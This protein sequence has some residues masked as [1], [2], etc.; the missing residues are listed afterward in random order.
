M[1][2]TFR[3]LRAYVAKQQVDDREIKFKQAR[4]TRS[5]VD[6]YVDL[7][8]AMKSSGAGRGTNYRGPRQTNAALNEYLTRL[9]YAADLDADIDFHYDSEAPLA[10]TFFL[11]MPLACGVTR[12]VLEGAPGQGKSTVTQFICQVNRIRLLNEPAQLTQLEGDYGSGPIRTPFRVDLRDYAVWL[13]GKHPF[14]EDEPMPPAARHRSLE[15]F[16]TMQVAWYAATDSFRQDDLLELFQRSHCL[17]VLDGF[18]EVADIGVR[19][20][21]VSEICD[22]AA[23][24]GAISRSAQIIL[25]SRPAAFARSPGF[26]ESD[27][28]HLRLTDLRLPDISAYRDKWIRA[29]GLTARE[30]KPIAATL[31]GKL[32]QPSHSRFGQKPNATRDPAAPSA[33]AGRGITRETHRPIRRVHEVV[34]QP[35][36][37][38]V[39]SGSSKA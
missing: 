29:E 28:V 13:A 34:L 19:T 35:G 26:P 14:A 23:R 2:V 6:L 31:S 32:S 4:L 11:A 27:W 18:D 37:R 20:E 22:A 38:K 15:S 25:T 21:M 7:P 39:R 5:L 16:L 33:H 9:D 24:L 10:A 30:A 1:A 17:I 36:G 8:L 12:F 3:S